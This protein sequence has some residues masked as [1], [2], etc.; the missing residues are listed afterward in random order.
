MSVELNKIQECQCSGS[1]GGCLH[2]GGDNSWCPKHYP[3]PQP[4]PSV[5]DA[6][7][8]GG[9]T[10]CACRDCMGTTVSSDWTKPELCSECADAGC[11]KYPLE[12]KQRHSW[13]VV[14][15]DCQRDDAYGE[16]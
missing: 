11:E 13:P 3:A 6:P 10:H 9:Y 15:Y 7:P 14:S 1:Q 8:Q 5:D 2:C 16:C 4:R 12:W